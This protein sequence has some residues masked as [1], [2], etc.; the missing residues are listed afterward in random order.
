MSSIVALKSSSDYPISAIS[1][2][3]IAYTTEICEQ[4]IPIVLHLALLVQPTSVITALRTS[5]H[6]ITAILEELWHEPHPSNTGVDLINK[7]NVSD[8]IEDDG[9]IQQRDTPYEVNVLDESSES[10]AEL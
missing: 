6:N 9:N 4:S 1:D 2:Y 3:Y 10:P 7:E 8:P 5:V